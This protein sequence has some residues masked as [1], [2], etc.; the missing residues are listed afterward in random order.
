MQDKADASAP[1]SCAILASFA[2]HFV[3]SVP[4]ILLPREIR[5]D[6]RLDEV[7][8]EDLAQPRRDRVLPTLELADDQRRRLVVGEER[9]HG[10]RLQ[11]EAVVARLEVA[12]VD[13]VA[14]DG[15]HG[16]PAKKR[17]ITSAA[18]S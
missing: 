11:E 5:E 2:A 16:S 8:V 6:P 14:V 10:H 9:R 18:K 7:V 4:P 12:L 15:D 17:W 3:Q 1:S 13:R